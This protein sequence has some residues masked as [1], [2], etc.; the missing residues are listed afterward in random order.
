[1][2]TRDRDHFLSLEQ[3]TAVANDAR[4]D[5]FLSIHANAATSRKPKGIETY[6]ASLDAT[7]ASGA[8]D[9]RA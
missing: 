2:L 7:D 6:F 4:A 8:S 5:L 1:M 9:G 3:R